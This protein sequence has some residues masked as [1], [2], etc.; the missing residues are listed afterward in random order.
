MSSHPRQ[1]GELQ[2]ALADYANAPDDP[3]FGQTAIERA[4]ELS[5]A[6]R[7][8]ATELNLLRERADRNM[9]QSVEE[10]NRLLAEFDEENDAVKAAIAQGNDPTMA[11]DRRDAIVAEISQHMGVTV[12]RREGGDMALFTD[13][14]IT[15]FDRSAREVSFTRTPVYTVNTQGGTVTVDGMPVTGPSAPMPLRS[16]SIVGAAR[17]REVLAQ[18]GRTQPT[19]QASCGSVFKN[20]PGDYA[21]RLIEQCGLKG[22]RHGGCQVSTVHANFIVNDANGSAADIESIIEHVRATVAR[23]TGVMLESE[24]QI[25]GDAE[26][27]Q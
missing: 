23:E 11:Q 19:G 5:Y 2:A 24:V 10:V 26:G 25:V 13:S 15:L 14:G 8:A 3:L 16:G 4:K 1:I 7:Q 17:I 22:Y 20:P 21:G 18:R 27:G 12:L 6:L 9:S